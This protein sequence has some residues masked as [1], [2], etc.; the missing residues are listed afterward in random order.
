MTGSPLEESVARIERSLTVTRTDRF[1]IER[2]IAEHLPGQTPVEFVEFASMEEIHRL[3]G[4]KIPTYLD[5]AFRIALLE[6]TSRFVNLY[7]AT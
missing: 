6:G 3:N 5:T 7:N 4:S 2:S 1:V